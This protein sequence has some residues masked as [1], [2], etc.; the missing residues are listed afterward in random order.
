MSETYV[1]V[2]FR[3]WHCNSYYSCSSPSLHPNNCWCYSLCCEACGFT[4]FDAL[5]AV[6][7]P[8]PVFRIHYRKLNMYRMGK[9]GGH[10]HL[11]P[12]RVRSNMPQ[13][14]RPS[15]DGPREVS[16]V[17]DNPNIPE[18]SARQGQ[19][20]VHREDHPQMVPRQLT[21]SDNPDG[22]P[23]AT[24]FHIS[25]HYP[26]STRRTSEN[27]LYEPSDDTYA[28]LPAP[29]Q[30]DLESSFSVLNPMYQSQLPIDQRPQ[31]PLPPTSS[32]IPMPHAASHISQPLDL[33]KTG[34]LVTN[35]SPTGENS[36]FAR[37][38]SVGIS[39]LLREGGDREF[40]NREQPSSSRLSDIDPGYETLSKYTIGT[41]M[42]ISP[43]RP[44][45]S[46]TEIGGLPD[47]A[48]VHTEPPPTSRINDNEDEPERPSVDPVMRPRHTY[49]NEPLTVSTLPSD[50]SSPHRYT[51]MA[52]HQYQG[53][54]ENIQ[55]Q[56]ND[57][58]ITAVANPM[59]SYPLHHS[60]SLSDLTNQRLEGSLVRQLQAMRA[61]IDSDHRS[62]GEGAVADDGIN[63]EARIMP[64][65]SVTAPS[66]GIQSDVISGGGTHHTYCID[67]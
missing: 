53:S 46:P 2:L 44:T 18:I 59:Y 3:N 48:Q 65:Q 7:H 17:I 21:Q 62:T 13:L 30:S 55:I 20:N 9:P 54:R 51:K 61:S 12:T 22:M 57:G 58:R 4:S 26:R 47:Q 28:V 8:F 67:V 63:P 64:V 15:G 60:R 23:V 56:Y 40:D 43:P 5:I 32:A 39:H 19:W 52:L 38:G 66:V 1:M 37:V 33:N 41:N 24:Q 50:P 45:T 25:D 10:T 16:M 34:L 42:S 35:V 36:T 29:Q 6:F 49:I 31:H 27:I 14:L 11:S